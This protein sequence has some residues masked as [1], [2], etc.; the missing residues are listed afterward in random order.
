[1][2]ISKEVLEGVYSGYGCCVDDATM[3]R[4]YALAT[5]A[6][7]P[8]KNYRTGEYKA[9]IPSPSAF[10][11]SGLRTIS[12]TTRCDCYMAVVKQVLC[13]HEVAF[14]LLCTQLDQDNARNKR[15][16]EAAQAREDAR[17]IERSAAGLEPI[18][19]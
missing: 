14:D 9:R 6:A 1:M 18:F 17:R 15:I 5:Q 16:R 13:K 8:V 11:G 3:E 2:N 7:P 4:G 10:D 12:T 19:S